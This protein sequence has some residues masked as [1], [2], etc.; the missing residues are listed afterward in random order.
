MQQEKRRKKRRIRIILLELV[1]LV[2]ILVF[3]GYTYVTSQLDMMTKLPWD[4]D[5]IRNGEISMEK[6]EQMEGYWTIAIFG[7]D[8]RTNFRFYKK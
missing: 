1:A 3:A 7:V 8:S 6:Q 4:P 2:A 5:K